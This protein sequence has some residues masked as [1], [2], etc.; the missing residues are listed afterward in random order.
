MRL[1]EAYRRAVELASSAA[2]EDEF[3][4]GCLGLVC[5]LAGCWLVSTRTSSPH[6]QLQGEMLQS[7]AEAQQAAVKQLPDAQLTLEAEQQARA[8]GAALLNEAV[9]V[10]Q[11]VLSCAWRPHLYSL[12]CDEALVQVTQPQEA[13]DDARVNCGNALAAWAQLEQ[14]DPARRCQLLRLA[15]RAYASTADSAED[16]SARLL[17]AKQAHFWLS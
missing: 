5:S 7:W 17:V 1:Q 4:Q 10:Y 15:L 9:Q 11:K 2:Q 6:H 16:T 12:A 3:A 13:K 14:A 8:Q